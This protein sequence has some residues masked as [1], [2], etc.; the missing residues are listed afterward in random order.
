MNKKNIFL[1]SLAIVGLLAIAVFAII[2]VNFRSTF[3]PIGSANED[4][5][6]QYTVPKDVL[7]AV[8]R[9]KSSGLPV[10]GIR[11]D[12]P[13]Y[14]IP[15]LMLHYVENVKD[16]GD[17]IRISLNDPPSLLESQ[18]K[19]LVDAGYTFITPSD[20]ADILDGIKLPPDKPIVL[21][22]DDGHRDFYTDAF[23]ILKKYNVKSVIYVI[24]GFLGQPDFLTNDELKEISES[25]LVEIGAHTVDHVALKGQNQQIVAKEVNNSKVFLESDLGISVTTFAYPYGSF[26][27]PSIQII[28][29]AGFRTAFST[30]PGT[31]VG[32]YNRLFINRLRPGGLTGNSLI[33]LINSK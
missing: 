7:Q 19:T 23:P 33:D 14:R 20:L 11:A 21:S 3:Q 29:E 15:V 12:G 8:D 31:E 18:I 26:D 2:K 32:N 16:K 5:L 27:L 10:L 13:S 17:T 9:A 6:S 22:F 30:V 25:G 28:K 1:P 24:T 4:A